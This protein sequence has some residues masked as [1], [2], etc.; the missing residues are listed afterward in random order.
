MLRLTVAILAV[1][2]SSAVA[3]GA[4]V[5]AP[6]AIAHRSHFGWPDYIA[7]AAYPLVLLVMGLLVRV[8]SS[9]VEGYFRGGQ[10]IP[11][12]AAGLSLVASQVSAIGFMAIPAKSFATDW[13]YFAGVFMWFAVVPIVN[14]YYIPLFRRLNVTTAYEY[15]ETRF[16]FPMRAFASAMFMI[17]TVL[18][19][20][21]VML[22]PAIAVSAVTG[23]DKIHCIL[24]MGIVTTVY[25]LWGG[26]ET[27]IWTDVV[28]AVTLLGGVVLCLVIVVINVGGPATLFETAWNDG[29]F[30]M[31][32][33]DWSL[34]GPAIW[35]VLIGNFFSR[36]AGLTADQSVVQR[37]QATPNTRA[38]RRALWTDVGVS[39]PWAFLIFLLGTALY[40]FYK[41][42]PALLD[43][44]IEPDQIV[45]LFIVERVPAGLAGLIIAAIFA[46]SLDGSLLSVSTVF[47][48]D[49][50][51]RLRPESSSRQRVNLARGITLG[52]GVFSTATGVVL[53]MSSRASLWDVAIR[54]AG[55]F[56]GGFAGLFVLGL[57]ARRVGSAAAFV[58]L[59]VSAV[60]MYFV[61]GAS[62]VSPLIYAAFGMVSC[63]VAGWL[64]SFVLVSSVQ[65]QEETDRAIEFQAMR[66]DG[67]AGCE[68]AS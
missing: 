51:G 50:Y 12:W 25:T 37:Y 35:V 7:L 3:Q 56:S 15:L 8:K 67:I 54:F 2:L 31:V 27:V 18:R 55:L 5:G 39:I 44:T 36:L 6:A 59:I 42:N 64:A 57:F 20:S 32:S 45:P 30:R 22:L 23:I 33:H 9:D 60:V 4:D 68:G 14:H 1:F 61:D 58:G 26:M 21:V 17:L 34:A 11:A 47:V 49:V 48:N 43:P 62:D 53:A 40:V 28:Q 65:S 13:T 10:Q 66:A 46:A 19:T 16:N 24:A 63:V 29:K 52:L 41:Q 38:A